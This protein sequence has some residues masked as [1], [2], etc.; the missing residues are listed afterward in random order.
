M[1]AN[2]LL[3]GTGKIASQFL[4]PSTL[5]TN[6]VFAGLTISDPATT[7]AS[8]TLET[9]AG[10]PNGMLIS[11]NPDGSATLSQEIA[12]GTYMSFISTDATGNTTTI[13]GQTT[14]NIGST[15]A[16]NPVVQVLGNPGFGQVYDV[17]YNPAVRQFENP[18]PLNWALSIQN[19]GAGTNIPINID[20]TPYRTGYYILTNT[21]GII[22]GAALNI[23]I[24]PAGI[25]EGYVSVSP[26]GGPTGNFVAGSGFI[27]N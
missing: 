3:D 26:S 14:V 16:P 2:I 20:F 11:K 17:R 23:Q 19:N 22:S 1:S 24:D 27:W 21:L 4:P 10:E 7:Q 8:I 18:A 9:I 5:P 13:L 15:T 25:V 6:P 12:E